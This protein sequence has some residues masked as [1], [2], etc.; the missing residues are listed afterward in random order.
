VRWAFGLH[1]MIGVKKP[2]HLGRWEGLVLN[3]LIGIL[4]ETEEELSVL[5]SSVLDRAFKGEFP[6]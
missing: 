2:P 1:T 3:S 5:I 6:L 4:S